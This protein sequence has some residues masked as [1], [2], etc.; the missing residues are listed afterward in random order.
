MYIDIEFRT[1]LLLFRPRTGRNLVDSQRQFDSGPCFIC[2]KLPSFI[3]AEN[4]Y[5]KD[6][7]LV[8]S[9]SFYK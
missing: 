2:V 6:K 1:S 8:E 9:Y 3:K 4:Y 7:T 5:N